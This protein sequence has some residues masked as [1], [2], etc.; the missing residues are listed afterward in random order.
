[1]THFRF[2]IT[3]D[4]NLS[5]CYVSKKSLERGIAAYK[6]AYPGTTDTFETTW[7]A[8]QLNSQA[9]LPSMDKGKY[10]EMRFGPQRAAN[11]YPGLV[12]ISRG[13]GIE[14]KLGGR[15]GNTHDPH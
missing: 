6:S 12:E 15:T 13:V 1:M 7:H 4:T 5:V 8:F 3:F 9:P 2:T 14:F 11:M 10:Y